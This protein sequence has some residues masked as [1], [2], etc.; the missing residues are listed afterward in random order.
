MRDTFQL[1]V[2]QRHFGVHPVKLHGLTIVE[3]LKPNDSFGRTQ[4]TIEL[5]LLKRFG[6]VVVRARLETGDNLIRRGVPR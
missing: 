5:A 6:N 3:G 2:H 1:T 4:A